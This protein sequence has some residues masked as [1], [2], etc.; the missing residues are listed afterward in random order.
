MSANNWRIP[1]DFEGWMRQMEKRMTSL[2]RRPVVSTPQDL[3]GPSL[4]P[5]ATLIDN[6][7]ADEA[8]L[9]GMWYLPVGGDNS[10]DDTYGWMVLTIAQ[11]GAGYGVQLAYQVHDA[12][13]ALVTSAVSQT[14]RFFTP[15]G[16]V[17][18]TYT[19]WGA[20]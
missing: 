16:E 14:R 4:G 15:S 7:N 20:L 11:S 19:L 18:R 17:G 8:S 13:G 12:S 2:E 10:P 6:A 3:M 5:W 1:Q 9:N